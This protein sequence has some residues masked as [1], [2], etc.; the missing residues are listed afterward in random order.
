MEAVPVCKLSYQ[1]LSPGYYG[2]HWVTKCSHRVIMGYI[3][4]PNVSTGLLGV[5]SSYQMLPPGYHGLHWVTKC[6]HRVTIGYI[7]LPNVSTR[8]HCVITYIYPYYA[9]LIWRRCRAPYRPERAIS[10]LL[11]PFQTVRDPYRVYRSS[12]RSGCL[13]L[14]WGSIW[15][16]QYNNL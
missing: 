10:G 16:Y 8:L 12:C 5:T 15:K 3:E 14:I 6:F 9:C 7:E 13:G 1:T 2:L 4:L 11:A